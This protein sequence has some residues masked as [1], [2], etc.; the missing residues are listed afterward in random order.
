MQG[1]A[2][3]LIVALLLFAIALP[4]SYLPAR[5]ATEVDLISAFREG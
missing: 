2:W 5:R 3:K 1:G 4:A